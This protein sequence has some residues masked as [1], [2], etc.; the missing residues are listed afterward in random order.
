VRAV[1]TVFADLEG[2]EAGYKVA[3]AVKKRNLLVNLEEFSG[4]P[5]SWPRCSVRWQKARRCQRLASSGRH[6][7]FLPLSNR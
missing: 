3:M 4:V 6:R 1:L 2:A 7:W 5:R